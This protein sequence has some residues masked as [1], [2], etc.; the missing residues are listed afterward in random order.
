MKIKANF[1]C[2]TGM[3]LVDVYLESERERSMG[4]EEIWKELHRLFAA[5]NIS[6]SA[7]AECFLLKQ[8]PKGNWVSAGILS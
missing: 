1:G 5:E 4:S 3:Y 8:D 7:V 2:D 6:I